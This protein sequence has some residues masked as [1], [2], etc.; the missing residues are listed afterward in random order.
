MDQ[1]RV[2]AEADPPHREQRQAPECG[3][4]ERHPVV[5]ANDARQAVLLE[6]APED[7]PSQDD[8]R[9]PQPVAG[10]QIPT[11]AIDEGER[12]IVG[13]VARLELPLEVGRPDPVRLRATRYLT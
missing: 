9:G 5:R 12:I 3:G 13:A 4:G 8:R 7:R 6:R 2:D 1:F 10:E 11:V